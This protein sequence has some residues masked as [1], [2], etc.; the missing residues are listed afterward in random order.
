[1]PTQNVKPASQT[2]VDQCVALIVLAFSSDP[3]ARWLCPDPH[4]FLEYF[5]RFVRAFGGKSFER[6]SAYYIDGSAA[7]LWLPPGAQPDEEALVA[8]LSDSVPL[9]DQGDLFAVLEQMSQN[10]PKEPHWYLPLIGTDPRQQSKGYGSALLRYALALRD[11]EEMP[12][13]LEATSPRNVPLY[14]RHGFEVVG[15]IKARTSPPITPML[16]KPR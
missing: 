12:A 6:G 5:P 4:A 3:A 15:T 9:S 13:Y 10:H 8:L 2:E 14:Q 7:A 16:R 1:M 11:R